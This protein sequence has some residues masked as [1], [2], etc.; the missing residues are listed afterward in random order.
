MMK[1]FGDYGDETTAIGKKAYASAQDIKTFSQMME[2][3]KAT[4]G[5]GWKETW[6]IVFGGLDEAKQFWTGVNNFISEIITKMTKF[7][8]GILE[9]ALGKKLVDVGDKFKDILAPATKV[10]DSVKK[11]SS[12]MENLDEIAKKVIRGDF[13]NGKE[14]LDKLTES[15]INYYTVQNKVNEILGNSHRYTQKQIE[16]QD[17]LLNSQNK[18]NESN[19]VSIKSLQ[20]LSDE[21]I[22]YIYELSKLSD[23]QIRAERELGKLSDAQLRSKGYTDEQIKSFR[24]LNEVS[25]EQIG[26][27]RELGKVAEELGM[28]IEK[29]VKFMDEIDGRWLIIDS[30]KN[31]GE[32]LGKILGGVGEA[33]NSQ[34]GKLDISGGIT[35]MI[36]SLHRFSEGLT[37]VE[38]TVDKVTRIAKGIFAFTKLFTSFGTKLSLVVLDIVKG[39]LGITKGNM[40]E[41]LAKL[42][43]GLVK[44]KDAIFSNKALA[45]SFDEL[46]PKILKVIEHVANLISSFINLPGVQKSFNAFKQVLSKVFDTILGVLSGTISLSEFFTKVGDAISFLGDKITKTFPFLSKWVSVIK[47]FFSSFKNTTVSSGIF[48]G[49]IAAFDKFKQRCADAYSAGKYIVDG[50]IQ[51]LKDGSMGLG[52]AIINIGKMLIEQF[53]SI[54]GIASPSKVMI[55]L[56]MFLIDGLI[57]GILMSTTGLGSTIKDLGSKII[58]W[59]KTIFD[60]VSINFDKFGSGLRDKFKNIDFGKVFASVVSIAMLALVKKI[61]DGLIILTKPLTAISDV[62]SSVKSLIGGVKGAI[63]NLG[64]AM[65]FETRTEGVKNLAMSIGIVLAAVAGLVFIINKFNIT[66]GEIF[67]ALGIMVAV[68]ALLLGVSW[69]MGKIS[70]STLDINKSGLSLKSVMPKLISL[71]VSLLLIVGV[72]KLL[73]NMT[74]EDYS[75]GLWRLAGTLVA[76][77]AVVSVISL[78]S[79][80]LNFDPAGTGKMLKKLAV[81]LLLLVLV[82]KLVGM[83]DGEELLK[84]GLFMAGFAA[85]V[86]AMGAASRLGGQHITEFG[87]TVMRL[88]ISL[89]LLVLV[90]KLIDTL[91]VGAILKGV[92][93]AVGFALFIA[94]LAEASKSLQSFEMTNLGGTL[95]S[96]SLTM[97]LMVGVCKLAGMLSVGELFKGSIFIVAMTAIIRS[98]V[99]T[100]KLGDKETMGQVAGTMMALSV[101]IATMAAV[102]IILGLMPI[103]YLAKGIT[104]VGLIAY[105]LKMIIGQLNGAQNVV[106]TMIAITVALGVLVAAIVGLSFIPTKDLIVATG[107][108][109]VV[110][111]MFA[112]LISTVNKVVKPA[113]IGQTV[114]SISMMIAVIAVLG[115]IIAGLSHITDPDSA[116]QSAGAISTL[117]LTLMGTLKI[118]GS[119]DKRGLKVGKNLITTLGLMIVVIGVLG[120]IIAGL[121]HITDPNSAIQATAAIS[122]LLIAMTGVMYALSVI[123]KLNKASGV[124]A[125]D[126]FIAIGQLA[127]LCVLLAGFAAALNYIPMNNIA[128]KIPGILATATT[129]VAMGALLL[130]IGAV[131]KLTKMLGVSVGSTFITIGELVTLCGLLAG[132]A[133]A[134]NYIPMGNIADKKEALIIVAGVMAAMTVLLLALSGVGALMMLMGGGTTAIAGI[135]GMTVLCGLLAGFAA[136]LNYIPMGNITGKKEAILLVAGIMTAMTV[137]LLALSVIGFLCVGAIAGIIELTAM[138]GLLV[139]FA[140]VLNSISMD[141]ISEN[142]DTILMLVDIITHLVGLLTILTQIGP[143][144]LVGVA[145]ITGLI[146]LIGAMTVLATAIG[147]LMEIPGL[148]EF[149]TN[150]IS[151]MVKVADGIGQIAA[152]VITGFTSNIGDSLVTL[153][154]QLSM[155]MI[156]LQ[157]FIVGVKMVDETVLA[158]VGILAAAVIALTAADLINGLASFSPFSSSFAELGAKLSS[159]IVAAL[160]FIMYSRMIDPNSMTGVKT[161]VQ[162]IMLLTAA[163]LL[164]RIT[165]WVSGSSSMETFKTQLLSFGDAI[166]AFS[167]KV[168]GNI[169]EGAVVAAANAGKTIA[170]LYDALPKEGGWMQTMFGEASLETFATQLTAFGEAIVGF[171]NKVKG[172]VDEE[173]VTAAANAGKTLA[174]LY[175]AIPKGGGWIQD[176]FGEANLE[177]FGTQLT[178][179]GEAIVSFSKKVKGNIDE[180]AVA[181]AKSAGDTMVALANSLPEAGNFWDIFTG[182]DKM[183]FTEFGSQ[184]SSFGDALIGF[185][186]KAVS[187]D[188]SAMDGVSAST[189][190]LISLFKSMTGINI[191]NVSTFKDAVKSLGKA[192]VE[193]FYESF[194]AEKAETAASAVRKI[195]KLIKDMAGLDTSGVGAFKSALSK[196]GTVEVSKFVDA[197]SSAS[198]KMAKAGT[199]MMTALI[200]GVN[201]GKSKLT[202]LAGNITNEVVR[203]ISSAESKFTTAGKKLISSLNDGADSKKSSLKSTV[204]SMVKSAANAAKEHKSTFKTA[205]KDLGQGLI[206]GINAKKQAAYDAGYALGKKAAQGVKDGEQSNSPSKLSIQYGKWLGEGL[207][208]GINKMGSPVYDAGYNMGELAANSISGAISKISDV[209]HSDIDAQPTIRPVLD[210]TDVTSGANKINGLFNTNRSVGVMAN[211]GVISSMMNSGQNGVNDDI[212][213]AIKDLGNSLSGKTGDTYQ[214]NGITYDDGTNISDAIGT[215]VRAVRV[216]RRR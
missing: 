15:G 5:T 159:F 151:L 145:S 12:A 62:L 117:L 163:E 4:A 87:K 26:V 60:N 44:I 52:Q 149:V 148:E 95:I 141:N 152:A 161:L 54:L 68:A 108:L 39:M 46:A 2:S 181:A 59:F 139:G 101:A 166:V 196:L 200:R 109:T 71:A 89:G 107:A 18:I 43:D 97:L 100:T 184:L 25:D 210:L 67:G 20:E 45:I 69:V 165:S 123:T 140:V 208:I 35:N 102:A 93:F 160:P 105:M 82:V 23:E 79:R 138:C 65:A 30:F 8:N 132:F 162:T 126:M 143:L 189:K 212:I 209:I 113:G 187:V 201:S 119:I 186:D 57:L 133:A 38:G 106:G 96:L 125:A 203:K 134:L 58:S 185:S 63:E 51:G 179:F 66:A 74:S 111:G 55:T 158:G 41:Y 40:L 174:Q 36:T 80:G 211:V 3:L 168:S 182:D 37:D 13:G 61:T 191:D 42:G 120:L 9:S 215:L 180:E 50:V 70:E 172:N 47:D 77:V 170:Q 171:S 73:A 193:D 27:F 33:W 85:F 28:P 157:P 24:K 78:V 116:L 137:L 92:G 124:S 136:A 49:I 86:L 131:S 156:A 110:M 169:D 29:F 178:A 48:D 53:C 91:S 84:G 206:N 204:T 147:L 34:F 121:S 14:R 104:A 83:L 127:T 130:A 56:G 173:A 188:A 122:A 75:A 214:I 135:I 115:L 183:D 155:F 114:K 213:S 129:M 153:G 202:T 81:T 16:A 88:A 150:G 164:E 205:G 146:A 216:E 17:E 167:S 64:K 197:F 103:E 10:A 144:A 177:T 112:F 192:K 198:S 190:K 22:K 142:R 128:G 31:I 1:V 72:I 199:D 90:I 6:E 21:E 19:T 32:A 207:I 76:L 99:Q 98:L 94:V 175:D 118:I 7:R 11:V 176:I 154:M 194:S 195:M